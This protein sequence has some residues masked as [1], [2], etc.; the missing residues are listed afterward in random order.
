M[1]VIE[2][3]AALR[4]VR[5]G[6]AGT[7]GLVPTM[8]YLH[9]GHLALV[10]AA[11]ADHDHVIATIFVNPLQFAAGE[12][13]AAYP[14]DLPRDLAL[15]A[16]AGVDVVFTPAPAEMYPPRYQTYITVAEVSQGREG[17]ARPEHFRGVATV[18]ARLF[19]LAQ[20]TTAYFGQKDAQQ[21]VVIR[22]MVR[23][24]HFPLEIAVCPTVREADGLALSSRNVYLTPAERPRAAVL[25]AA[26]QAAADHYA[27]GERDPAALRGAAL[28]VLHAE[29]LAQVDYVS[30]ADARTLDEQTTPTAAPLLLSLAAQFGRPRLLDN[31]LLPAPLNTRAG[32]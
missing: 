22:Q 20:P 24:L 1:Q 28:A 31:W 32:L 8:G 29:P 3:I 27:A 13:L 10:A 11:R 15:L 4:R 6:L 26:M 14:R 2:T 25:Y 19:N 16:A 7:V 21:V 23:D 12:D 9:A 17:R 30:V 5:A 18:V